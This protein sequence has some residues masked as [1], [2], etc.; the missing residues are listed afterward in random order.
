MKLRNWTSAG[1]AAVLMLALVGGVNA[2]ALEDGYAAA[3]RGDYATAYRLWRPLAEQGDAEAQYKLGTMYDIGQ[4]VPLDN[5]K[6][7]RWF[8]KAAEQGHATAQYKL[9]VMYEAGWGVP[10]DYAKA[11]R[12]FRKAAE[13]GDAPS[14]FRLGNMYDVGHGVPQDYVEA[15]K[16]YSLAA[17]AGEPSATFFRDDTAKSMTPAQIAEAQRLAREWQAKKQK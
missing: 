13:Q 6:A 11:V 15:H 7:G 4:G 14:Q 10:Q 12:W 5:A 8:R 2:G 17:A 3:E 1:V 16:W 9:G